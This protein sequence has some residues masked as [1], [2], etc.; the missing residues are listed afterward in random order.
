M[1]CCLT[2]PQLFADKSYVGC[3]H[4]QYFVGVCPPHPEPVTNEASVCLSEQDVMMHKRQAVLYGKWNHHQ[5]DTFARD[6]SHAF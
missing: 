6:P 4:W 5:A 1:K 3:V 2:R